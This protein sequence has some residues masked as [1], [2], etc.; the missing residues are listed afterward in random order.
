MDET[1]RY[2][3]PERSSSDEI[4]NQNRFIASQ[5]LFNEIFGTMTGVSAIINANRQIIYAND[6]FLKLL[7]LSGIEP[8]LG[9]RLGEVVS[10]IHSDEQPSGCGTSLACTYCG[11]V[12]SILESQK[13]GLKSSRETRI[14]TL[15]EGKT[16][17]LDLNVITSPI[18]LGNQK[19][20]VVTLQD[21]SEEKRNSALERIFFH[22]LLNT[23]GGLNGLLSILKEATNPMESSE[24]INLSEEA[25]RNLVEEIL[26]HRQIRAA[27]NGE[28]KVQLDLVNTLDIIK[29]AIGK[30]GH[31]EVGKEKSIL[32]DSKSSDL[33]FESDRMLLQRVIINL[34]KN[35]LE[36]TA[37]GG[38][39]T[40]GADSTVEKVRFW[41]KN[42]AVIPEEVQL[43]LFQRSFS[44]KGN[45]RGIGTYS[46]R[47]LT[48][49]YLKGKVSFI[50]NATDLT[51]FTIELNR[52]FPA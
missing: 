41:V 28:L 48:E 37:K 4:I 14:S 19:Y 20:F 52:V 13:T 32:I 31:H 29:S 35:A 46:I 38:S 39:V 34:L 25:S 17:S 7:G 12:N 16:K 43:Q 44:T 10:C 18:S 27:E 24:L 45:G 40:L 11:A 23:A 26:H 15:I 22:D 21:I 51:V 6:D 5:K 3:S 8:I 2:A 30:I 42:N 49:N 9:K 1:T 50:S 47:L 36:A 33:N